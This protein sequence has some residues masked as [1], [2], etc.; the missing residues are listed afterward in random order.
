LK[1]GALGGALLFAAGSLPIVFRPSGPLAGPTRPLKQLTAT[2]YGIFAAAA[3]RLVLGADAH[4]DPRWPM[5]GAV[6]CAGK[7]DDILS[8]LH[9]RAAGEFRKLLRLFENGMTGLLWLGRPQ[10][11]TAASPEEQDRRLQ[12]WRHS[13]LALL[14]SGYQAIKRLAHATYYASPA[15]FAAVGYPGPPVIP[16]LD[17]REPLFE[18]PTSGVP[19]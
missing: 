4:V 16:E 2:E 15:T 6:D 1:K 19:G 12:A 14:R 11:F 9:P 13:R 5:P 18:R 3:A 8:T 10:T 7:L 17:R